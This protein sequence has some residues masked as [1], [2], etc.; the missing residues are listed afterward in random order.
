M[1]RWM[2]IL[3]ALVLLSISSAH[4]GDNSIDITAEGSGIAVYQTSSGRKEIGTL[5]NGY[6]VS[7][8]LED[9]NGLYSCWL[10]NDMTVWMDE[11]KAL[12]R[13]P[14]D[15]NGFLDWHAWRDMRNTVPCGMF[16]A[17]VTEEEAPLYTSPGHKNLVARHK[18][19]TLMQVCGEFGDDYF[20]DMGNICG[21]IPKT[22]VKRYADVTM[23]NRYTWMNDMAVDE[24]TVHTGGVP[25]ALGFSATGYCAEAPVTVEDGEKVKVLKY[26]DGW[27]QLAGGG[28]IETRFLEEKG[29]HTICY[30]TV[31][32]SEKLNR[33]NVRRTADKES[34]VVMKLFSGAKVQVPCHTEDWAAVY[35]TGIEGS[36]EITGSAMMEYLVF[37]D[38]T[39]MDGCIPVRVTK[40]VYRGDGSTLY[41]SWDGNQCLP[42]GEKLTVIGVEGEYDIEWDR[43]DRF[44]CQTADGKVVVIW[45]GDGV[46]EPEECT[47]IHVRTN[48]SVRM[49]QKPHKEAASLRTLSSGTKVEVMLRGEGWTMVRYK[50]QTGYVMSRYLN[51]P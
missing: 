36:V 14:R 12:A 46:L 20:V 19:G 8:S 31:K 6:F 44:L 4:A 18:K 21:F 3:L 25:L 22:A 45:N 17:E 38:E 1:K 27:A 41:G 51:F 47:G 2:L 35:V 43:G 10:T 26:L 29:D 50:E 33:L 5:Y 49:R 40:N 15:E 16:V 23:E 13:Y 39:V 30:A 34:R 37:D 42:A 11:D 28:F 9:T 32:S 7:L 48:A 24:C